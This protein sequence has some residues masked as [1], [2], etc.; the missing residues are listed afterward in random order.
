[1]NRRWL[2]RLAVVAWAVT[3]IVLATPA[4]ADATVDIGD[5]KV[6]LGMP[7][8][9]LSVGLAWGD[10]RSKV[11]RNAEMIRDHIRRHEEGEY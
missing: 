8:M 2:W 6:P 11:S 7:L 3:L 5:M 1:M 4:L 10:L 9:F